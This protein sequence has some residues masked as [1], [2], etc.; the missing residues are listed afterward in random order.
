MEELKPCPFC[1][2]KNIKINPLFGVNIA[3]YRFTCPG[4]GCCSGY[5]NTEEAAAVLWNTRSGK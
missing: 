2:C 5:E 4:C 1:G 3:S